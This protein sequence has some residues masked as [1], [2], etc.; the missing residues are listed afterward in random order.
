[1]RE[2]AVHPHSPLG[3]VCEPEV[4]YVLVGRLLN[5][6]VCQLS[7]DREEGVETWLHRND[8]VGFANERGTL[9]GEDLGSYVCDLAVE[10]VEASAAGDGLRLR[11][12]RQA[13][14]DAAGLT[15]VEKLCVP[16]EEVVDAGSIGGGGCGDSER[17]RFGTDR[18]ILRQRGSSKTAKC[19]A[20]LAPWR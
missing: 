17:R 18:S 4:K 12:L 9:V 3:R 5:G 1:M 16:C 20:P 7:I 13:L 11:V 14:S 6:D 8:D 10:D 15:D 19:R 2:A